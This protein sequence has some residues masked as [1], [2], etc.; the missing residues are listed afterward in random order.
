MLPF[1]SF[2]NYFFI[3]SHVVIILF[4]LSGWISRRTRKLHLFLIVVTLL[5]WVLLGY[6]YG[7]GY[8]FWTDWHWEVRRKLELPV[9][10]SFVKLMLDWVTGI[11]LDSR[12]V[13][14]VTEIF[15]FL[16][17]GLSLYTNLRDYSKKR[18]LPG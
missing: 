11:D 16:A 10:N 9:P 3:S 18:T 4:T 17:A 1:Y 15:L 7:W 14:T 5:S 8:C 12:S 13:D 2:L 6:W